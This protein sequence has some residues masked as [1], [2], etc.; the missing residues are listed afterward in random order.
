VGNIF[1]EITVIICFAA[2]LAVLFRVFKQPAILAYILTGIIFSHL[3][4]FNNE[5][6]NTLHSLAELGITLLL[7]MLGLEIKIKELP[8]IGK[9]ASIVGISQILATGAIGYLI[10]I[11][12]GYSQIT[13]LY[14][15]SAIAF[16]STIIVVKLLS[17]KKD[18]HSLYGKISVGILLIQDVFAIGLLIFLSSFNINHLNGNIFLTLMLLLYK[19][20]ILIL[21][22]GL[23]SKYLLPFVLDFVAK[24][25]ETLFLFSLAWVFGLAALVSSNYIG[26]SIEIGGFI[27]GLSLSSTTE[28]YQIAAR[29]KTLRD[30]FIVLF[31]VLLGAQ[32]SIFSISK[33]IIPAIIISLFVLLI[34][35]F[36]VMIVMGIMGYRKRTSFFTGVNVSQISEF[37]LI[38]IF[39][40]AKLGQVDN[41][42]VSL[43]TLVG[44]IT[45]TTSSFMIYANNGLY[46]KLHKFMFFI[47]RKYIKAESIGEIGELTNHT[48]LVGGNSMGESIL[49]S[50]NHVKD[51]LVVVDFDPEVVKKLNKAKIKSLFGDIVDF[52]IQEKARLH[53][54]KLVIS[55]ISDLDDNLL[56]IKSLNKINRRAKIIVI[57]Q[58]QKEARHLYKKGADFV[59]IPYIAGG[60][61]VAKLLRENK[62][63]KLESL[64]EEEFLS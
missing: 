3:G 14:I 54:A 43:I 23:V 31:F 2:F 63:E 55:T 5:A 7:F 32:M 36:L 24:S 4:V 17:D 34:K 8:T 41:N 47:E 28:N 16:S 10:C 51:N 50:L 53:K 35:P 48:V 26:F 60:R 49:S 21:V 12:I 62:L 59:V 40:G 15:S 64:K 52:D 37:S 46:H 22:I 45:F 9:V 44:I 29:M 11:L 13:S 19:G 20:L 56:L 38:L 39:L 18:L 1:F 57:A 27:A 58:D 6:Q 25:S 61:H 42:V 33:I 30:F